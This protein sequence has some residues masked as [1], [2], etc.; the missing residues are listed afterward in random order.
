MDEHDHEMVLQNVDIVGLEPCIAHILKKAGSQ[1]RQVVKAELAELDLE[2]LRDNRTLL[3]DQARNTYEEQ[4]RQNNV[5]NIVQIDPKSRRNADTTS[6]DIID[7]YLC[8]RILNK[9]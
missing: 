6:S 7:L 4:L 3:F 2:V 1:P 9:V 5:Q 8:S